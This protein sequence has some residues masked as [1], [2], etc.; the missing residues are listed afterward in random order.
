MHNEQ[1]NDEGS[2]KKRI[3]TIYLQGNNSIKYRL[4]ARVRKL[5]SYRIS[6]RAG[7]EK[8]VQL[9]ISKIANLCILKLPVIVMQ[10]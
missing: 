9:E 4:N 8:Y 7:R 10:K 5:F 3:G 6:R 2:A 1:H